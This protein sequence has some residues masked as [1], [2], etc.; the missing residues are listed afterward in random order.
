[1]PQERAI[2]GRIKGIR[3]WEGRDAYGLVNE[4][5]WGVQVQFN[6]GESLY[7]S[8]QTFLISLEH[9]EP[10][11]G[12]VSVKIHP[13][14]EQL[15]PPPVYGTTG[16]L[17]GGFHP[18]QYGVYRIW[19]RRF[20]DIQRAMRRR[21]RSITPTEGDPNLATERLEINRDGA[22]FRVAMNNETV[23]ELNRILEMYNGYVGARERAGEAGMQR[24]REAERPQP[25]PDDYLTGDWV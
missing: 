2:R 10:L 12:E 14:I 21:E 15:G 7:N 18:K 24:E 5:A 16:C 1:M 23:Q 6:E 20:C 8:Q 25:S 22:S 9:F 3:D 11:P 17:G 19:A 4:G 13:E